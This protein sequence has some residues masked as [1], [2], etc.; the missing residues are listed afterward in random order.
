VRLFTAIPVSARGK[1]RKIGL[2]IIAAQHLRAIT[3][4]QQSARHFASRSGFREE[5]EDDERL[6]ERAL[7]ADLTRI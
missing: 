4:F 1:N 3:R 7:V 2:W 5:M 6:L